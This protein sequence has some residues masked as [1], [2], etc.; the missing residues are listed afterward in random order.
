MAPNPSD[1][2]RR[3]RMQL[4]IDNQ[5]QFVMLRVRDTVAD[6]WQ[7]TVSAEFKDWLIN[8]LLSGTTLEGASDKSQIDLISVDYADI[9]SDIFLPTTSTAIGELQAGDDTGTPLTAATL[10]S[11]SGRS[12][13]GVARFYLRGLHCTTYS[14]AYADFR[15]S[16]A[17]N[18]AVLAAID[19]L[20]PDAG[21]L[22]PM[23]CATDNEPVLYWKPYMNVSISR[24]YIN[25]ARSL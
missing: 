1:A 12:V 7:E 25:H 5:T 10:V 24:R 8:E 9:G 3:L 23:L 4:K 13:G 6:G 2:T 22:G 16:T 18:V 20:D 14:T 15:L 19:D 17:E 21:G 11:F